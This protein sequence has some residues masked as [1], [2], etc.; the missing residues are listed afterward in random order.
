[1]QPCPACQGQTKSSASCDICGYKFVALNP[2]PNDEAMKRTLWRIAQI[3][4]K[5]ESKK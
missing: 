2:P 5:L 4:D 1:M 3:L